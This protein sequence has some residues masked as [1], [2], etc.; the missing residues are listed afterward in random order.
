M[1]FTQEYA[2]L[3][4]VREVPEPDTRGVCSCGAGRINY[5]VRFSHLSNNFC[6]PRICRFAWVCTMEFPSV[7]LA[8]LVPPFLPQ[9]ARYLLQ[10]CNTANVPYI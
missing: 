8:S 5:E 4:Q 3:T 1:H 2:H 9:I 6:G 7:Y 10:V